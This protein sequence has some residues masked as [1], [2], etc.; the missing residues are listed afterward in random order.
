MTKTIGV[1]NSRTS[2]AGHLLARQV[3]GTTWTYNEDVDEEV[4][5]DNSQ[6][7]WLSIS[8]K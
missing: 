1:D 5:E 8:F 3:T 2:M 4:D 7:T 6:T